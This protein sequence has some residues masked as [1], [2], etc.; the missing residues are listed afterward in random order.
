MMTGLEPRLVCVQ[1]LIRTV[2]QGSYGNL[3]LGAAMKRLDG[4]GDREAAEREQRLCRALFMGTLER[5]VTLDAVI[6][7]HSSRPP[8]KLDTEVL[9]VLRCGICELLAMH[10]PEAAAV[11]L[12]TETVKRL[13]KASAAGAVNAVLRGFLRADKVIPVPEEPLSALSVRYSVP[14]PLVRRLTDGLGAKAAEAFMADSLGEP[15]LYF[16]QNP[17]RCEAAAL[18]EK[19]GL[20]PVPGIPFAFRDDRSGR[21]TA[22]ARPDASVFADGWVH[23]QDLASQL[24]CLA[25]DAQPGE[26]VLDV[27]AAPGGKTFAIAEMMKNSGHLLAYD[28]H[29]QRVRL[30]QDGAKRLGLTC[31]TAQTG[32]ARR[33]SPDRPQADRVL[34]DVPCSGFGVMRRKPE[35]RYKSLEEAAGLPALQSEIL[36]ASAQAVKPGGVLVYSTCT[37]LK[38]ENEEVVSRFLAAHPEFSA[39]LPFAAYPELSEKTGCQPMTT[40]LPQMLGTDGFFIAKLRRKKG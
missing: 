23:V 18:T 38:A 37:V 6:A 1:T 2:K 36:E 40:L 35:V 28:L 10:T 24:C 13:R 16:R 15:P 8:E 19:T 39:E 30:I 11:N 12:W 9:C 7:V 5:L 27:C 3:A 34:C 29:P 32:D 20:T 4:G 14:L 33:P 21:E 17:L 26:T 22:G 31:I 25:L